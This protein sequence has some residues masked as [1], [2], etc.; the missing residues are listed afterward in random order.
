M[1]SFFDFN[2]PKM[3]DVK[4]K[5]GIVE[6]EE[7]A[8]D[9]SSHVSANE[10]WVEL[11]PSRGSLCSSV[12]VGMVMVDDVNLGKDS[13]LSP[14]SVQS[15][16]VEFDSLEQVKYKLVRDMLP[17]GKNTDWIWDWSSRPEAL[18]PKCVR[19]RQYGSNLTTPPNSPEPE[20]L[21]AFPIERKDRAS[22]LS[23]NMF[24]GFIVSNLVTLVIGAAIGFAVC[25][26]LAKQKEI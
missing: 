10:S 7:N 1:S 23:M 21:A 6:K 17:P 14:V 8:R 22:Y 2:R 9:T 16:H 20:L 12:D 18:P 26:R 11:A 3:F 5:L 15:P 25:R 4:K 19:M 13:R 24:V